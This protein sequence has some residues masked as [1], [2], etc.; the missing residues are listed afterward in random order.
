[1][2]RVCVCV[3]VNGF[4]HT[5]LCEGL[6]K[7]V[8]EW[9]NFTLFCSYCL[10][11]LLCLHYFARARSLSLFTARF[12]TA[13]KFSV[14][15]KINVFSYYLFVLFNILSILLHHHFRGTLSYKLTKNRKLFCAYV[16][17]YFSSNNSTALW[18]F[19]VFCSPEGFDFSHICLYVCVCELCGCCDCPHAHTFGSFAAR[20]CQ[21]EG[22]F[23]L[24]CFSEGKKKF[25]L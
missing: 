15:S 4:T 14:G 20:E 11:L 6:L 1:M 2:S 8:C 5:C 24:F 17:K 9:M 13:L 22:R 16:R 21:W 3:M 18:R 12:F 19:S 25:S 10:V 7:C 23:V